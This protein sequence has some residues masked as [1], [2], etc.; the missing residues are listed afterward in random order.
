M[1]DCILADPLALIVGGAFLAVL[2]GF[3]AGYS[4]LHGYDRGHAAACHSIRRNL[5]VAPSDTVLRRSR[6][7]DAAA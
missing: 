1:T 7:G 3:M 4:W 2:V 6:P 5:L